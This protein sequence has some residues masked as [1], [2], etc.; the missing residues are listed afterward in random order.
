M[1]RRQR[2][3]AVVDFVLI[4]LLLVPL[5]LGVLQVSLVL[6]VRNTLISAATEGA[7]LAATSDRDLA[8]GVNRTREELRGVLSA[9]YADDIRASTRLVAGAPTVEVAIRARVPALGIGGPAISLT[10]TGHAVQERR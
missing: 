1:A 9:R 5:F 7:R 3:A 8:A 4:L 10:V 6:Y 2:G